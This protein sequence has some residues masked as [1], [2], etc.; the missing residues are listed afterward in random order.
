M[1]ASSKLQFVHNECKY[2]V[3]GNRKCLFFDNIG[4]DNMLMRNH[5]LIIN[6]ECQHIYMRNAEGVPSENSHKFILL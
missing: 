2:E 5:K 4:R 6:I 3:S 1:K